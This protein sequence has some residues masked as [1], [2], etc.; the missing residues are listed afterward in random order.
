MVVGS[1]TAAMLLALL[2]ACGG[3]EATPSPSPEGSVAA[4]T[5][6]PEA[7]PASESPAEEP[8]EPA[9]ATVRMNA[10][11]GGVAVRSGPTTGDDVLVRVSEGTRVRV[12]E[13]VEGDA[14]EAGSCGSSGSDW[15][16]I[17]R[18]AG[19]AASTAYGV[20]YVYAAAGFFE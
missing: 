6:A 11:C 7:A 14:Y 13:T 18:V 2:A 3:S 16:K 15:L 4:P 10:L 8:A 1:V 20:P 9:D 17:D 12:V 19:K 5:E